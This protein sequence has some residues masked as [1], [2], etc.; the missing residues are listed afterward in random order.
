MFS[1]GENGMT[2]LVRNRF[3]I[4]IINEIIKRNIWNDIFCRLHD[5][6]I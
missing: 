2:K 5:K 4:I 6:K 1:C 3:H